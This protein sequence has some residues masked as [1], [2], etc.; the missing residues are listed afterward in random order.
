MER[1]FG[2]LE[3]RLPRLGAPLVGHGLQSLVTADR[4]SRYPSQDNVPGYEARS[5]GK[6][7]ART[8]ARTAVPAAAKRHL[9]LVLES[10]FDER[11]DME[12][13]S[14]QSTLNTVRDFRSR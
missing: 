10:S 4:T 13:A 14:M 2:A 1:L 11:T 3:S 7:D 6:Y 12:G 8:L 5:V 9:C